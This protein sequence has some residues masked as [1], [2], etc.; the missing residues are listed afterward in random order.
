MSE[1]AKVESIDAIR[2][3]RVALIK[4]AET[5]NVALSD[6]ESDAT[7]TLIWLEHEQVRFWTDQL[8]KRRTMVERCQEALRMKKLYRDSSGRMPSAVDEEK[9]LRLAVARYEEAER[10]HAATKKAVGVLTRE[11]MLYKG[12][13]QRMSTAAAADVPNAVAM[14]AGMLS[15]L[16]EYV[17]L[18]APTDAAS[19]APPGEA[20]P[21][22]ARPVDEPA[23]EVSPPTKPPA[24]TDDAPE[25]AAGADS[26]RDPAAG[27]D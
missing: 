24:P 22:V 10:K 21:S 6:A 1:G 17:N 27:T 8:R 7:R 12:S 3:L 19:Q 16:N 14:L 18:Q 5:A 26:H 9:A 15:Q 23:D 4:F 2:Q 13:V 20:G 25:P 11:M